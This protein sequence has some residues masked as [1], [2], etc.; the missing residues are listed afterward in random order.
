MRKFGLKLLEPIETEANNR[1]IHQMLI[2]VVEKHGRYTKGLHWEYTS[3]FSLVFPYISDQLMGWPAR[4]SRS[5]SQRL[6][7]RLASRERGLVEISR[8]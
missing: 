1:L 4:R 3:T 8:R 7:L 5:T 2:K 6:L